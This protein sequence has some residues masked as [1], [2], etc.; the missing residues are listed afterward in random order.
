MLI[1]AQRLSGRFLYF[2][3]MV[4]PD[5]ADPN[6]NHIHMT[7]GDCVQLPLYLDGI[8]ARTNI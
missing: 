2:M 4:H 1:A 7:F 6:W 8:D 3:M 5:Q